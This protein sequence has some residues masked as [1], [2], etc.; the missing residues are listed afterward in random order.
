ME[1]M[2]KAAYVLSKT[3]VMSAFMSM[4]VRQQ[5]HPLDVTQLA[6]YGMHASL[7]RH[8]APEACLKGRS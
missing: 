4:Y 8:A 3:L 1:R 5:V 7:A 6:P 2:E